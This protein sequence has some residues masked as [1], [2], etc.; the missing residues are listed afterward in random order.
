MAKRVTVKDVAAAAGVSQATVS[1]VLNET[2]GQTIPAPTR[3]RVHDAVESL[4]YTPSRAA[5]ALRSGRSD[6]VLLLL[7][8]APIGD[9]IARF[10]EWVS[11]ALDADGY[12][13]IYRRKSQGVSAERLVRELSPAVVFGLAALDAADSEWIARSRVPVIQ[14]GLGN[15]ESEALV[16]PQQDIGELQVDHLVSRGHSRI[17]VTQPVS[18]SLTAFLAPRVAGVRR[19]CAELSLPEPVG[20]TLDLDPES[21]AAAVQTW[22]GAGVTA[23]AAYNDEYAAAVLAGLRHLGL[24]A[25]EDLA[26][27]GV[28]NI[29]F[30]RL[31]SPPLTSVDVHIE[32]VTAWAI[33]ALRTALRVPDPGTSDLHRSPVSL[34]VRESA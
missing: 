1:Y 23:V 33:H 20:A 21:A 3:K 6:V 24:S 25:P 9:N 12:L 8:D 17:G 19:R 28:D 22:R 15:D 14:T 16:V 27:I 31:T 26:V 11:D 10:I 2:P 30:G 34:V 18:P 29:R 4:G 7:P 5:R 13:V 32:V